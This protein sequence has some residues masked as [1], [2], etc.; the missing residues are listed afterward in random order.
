MPKFKVTLTSDNAMD[1]SQAMHNRGIPT[2]GPAMTGFTEAP[3]TWTVSEHFTAVLEAV[4]AEN[5]V[6]KINEVGVDAEVVGGAE[7]WGA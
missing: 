4:D 5:A 2:I 3:E 6:A 7:P 1:A